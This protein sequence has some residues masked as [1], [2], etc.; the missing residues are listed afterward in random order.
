MKILVHDYSGH[1]FQVQLSRELARRGSEVRHVFSASFQTPKGNLSKQPDDPAGFDVI[2][3]TLSEAFDKGSFVKRRR[4]EIEF[5]AL[6]SKEIEAFAPDVVISSNA[7]LDCQRLVWAT[8]ERLN[9]PKVFW[10][11]DVYSEAIMRILSAKIPLFGHLV[12]WF[13]QAIEYNLLRRSQHVVAIAEDFRP[14]LVAHKVPTEMI[15]SIENWAPLDELTPTDRR[16]AWADENMDPD[17][18]RIVYSGTLGFKHNP[19]H[20]KALAEAAPDANVYV[21]S[22]GPG[23]DFLKAANLDNLIVRPW[24]PYENLSEMLSG[25]D[26]L[27][28]LLEEDAGVFSVPSKVLTYSCIG[29]PLVGSIPD[30]NLAKSIIETN[31]MGLVS[32]PSDAQALVDNV[33]SLLQ[34]EDKQNEMGKNARA[35]AERT[36]DIRKI[37][38]RFE[39]VLRNLTP[40]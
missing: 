36:F 34:D 25:A 14:I 2:P 38:D 30:G 35:Y 19:G 4:Q 9:I 23:A 3:L 31:T 28:V 1:P 16:N 18:P 6:L 37:T 7:P 24:V 17:K 13:Y 32:A 10:I 27:V 11:Q 40:R 33:L 12:G 26:L 21:F 20:L 29:R 5:G 15:T 39:D 8:C 22:E